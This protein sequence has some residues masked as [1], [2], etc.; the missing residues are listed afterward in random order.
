MQNNTKEV[1][2]NSKEK[3]KKSFLKNTATIIFVV[4]ISLF[5]LH[6]RSEIKNLQSEVAILEFEKFILE[7]R[8]NVLEERLERRTNHLYS[9]ISDIEFDIDLLFIP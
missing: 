1:K 7:D 4:A 5:A 6:N 2:I 8:V 3:R 9:R